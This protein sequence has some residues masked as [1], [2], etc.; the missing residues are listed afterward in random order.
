MREVT[1]TYKGQ[2]I[3]MSPNAADMVQWES[4]ARTNKI[5]LDMKSSDFPRITHVTYLA[6][7]CGRRAGH[8]P[9]EMKFSEFLQGFEDINANGDDDGSEDDADPLA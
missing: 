5:P 8:W 4:H 1:V 9:K 3:V 7:S 6:Y 2:E